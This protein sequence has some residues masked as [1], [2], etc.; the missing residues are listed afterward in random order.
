MVPVPGYW[1]IVPLAAV[2]LIF[3]ILGWIYTTSLW[4]VFAQ[5][6]VF[7]GIDP[8]CAIEG[9]AFD[10]F[11]ASE[12]QARQ[13]SSTILS[14]F[15]IAVASSCTLGGVV[16]DLSGW[17]GVSAYHSICQGLQLLLICTQPAVHESFRQVFFASPDPKAAIPNPEEASGNTAEKAFD[18]VVPQVVPQVA[19]V[20]SIQAAM[21]LPGAVESAEELEVQEV[22]ARSGLQSQSESGRHGSHERE[23][24]NPLLSWDTLPGKLMFNMR[25]LLMISTCSHVPFKSHGK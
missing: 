11:G 21:N 10:T 20:E 23:I 1:L 22:T 9:I 15:T 7:L 19:P 18:H 17:A 6:V 2:H 5:I 12:V 3:A 25:C 14:I 13:A 8:T 4:A 24:A 16:Y